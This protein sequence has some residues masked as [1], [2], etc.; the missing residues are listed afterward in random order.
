MR[1]SAVFLVVVVTIALAGAG[2]ATCAI[3]ADAGMGR[4]QS[5]KIMRCYEIEADEE[6]GEPIEVQT[7]PGAEYR[8]VATLVGVTRTLATI[9]CSDLPRTVSIGGAWPKGAVMGCALGAVCT[10]AR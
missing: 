4:Q 5:V 10:P 7:T 8:L 2:I 3:R 1:E 6:T 9:P